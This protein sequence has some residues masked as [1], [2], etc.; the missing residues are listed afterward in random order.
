MFYFQRSTRDEMS[1][2][3]ERNPARSLHKVYTSTDYIYTDRVTDFPPA[4]HSSKTNQ[5][6]WI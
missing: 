4:C 3:V 2:T 1:F 6:I 5:R